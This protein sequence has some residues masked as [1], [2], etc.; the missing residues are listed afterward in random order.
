MMLPEYSDKATVIQYGAEATHLLYCGSVTLYDMVQFE[1]K[2]N[3]AGA[4]LAARSATERNAERL[5][6][7]T[8]A[9]RTRSRSRSRS[10]WKRQCQK[11]RKQAGR[12]LWMQVTY[13]VQDRSVG[14]VQAVGERTRVRVLALV[15][16]RGAASG[17]VAQLGIGG[18]VGLAVRDPLATEV[19]AVL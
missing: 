19:G 4:I 8:T 5:A 17:D 13:V 3:T 18:P 1:E 14:T 16:A 10:G 15:V 9:K 6:L 11:M 2:D 12:H 7:T